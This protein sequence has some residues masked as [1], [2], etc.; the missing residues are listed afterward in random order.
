M[1]RILLTILLLH[2]IYTPAAPRV[3]DGLVR[4]GPSFAV[5]DVADNDY[6]YYYDDYYNSHDTI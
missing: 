4:D 1:E 5:L 2:G 6:D 3:V